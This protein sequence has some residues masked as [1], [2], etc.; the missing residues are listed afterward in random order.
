MSLSK[1][2][3]PALRTGIVIAR[4]QLID[5]LSATNSVAATTSFVRYMLTPVEATPAGAEASKPAATN[6]GHQP[7]LDSKSTG[8]QRRYGGTPRPR[9]MSRWRFHA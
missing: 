2:G 3:L 6:C 7:P 5:A 1:I 9:A 8:T 4:P